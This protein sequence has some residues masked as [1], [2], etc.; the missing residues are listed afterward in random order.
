MKLIVILLIFLPFIVLGTIAI[1]GGDS[2]LYFVANKSIVC[3]N[4][5]IPMTVLE[6]KETCWKLE[7]L[8]TPNQTLL[9]K[10]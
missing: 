6:Q 4:T 9:T 2:R 5:W 3:V 10:N 1:F 8:S 7:L